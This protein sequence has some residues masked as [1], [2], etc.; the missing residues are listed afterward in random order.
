[1]GCDADDDGG[2][3]KLA[4]IP[5]LVFD[6]KRGQEVEGRLDR[7][8]VTLVLDYMN[9]KHGIEKCTEGEYHRQKH[10]MSKI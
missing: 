1:M 4:A 3:I 2:S 6:N 5:R 7:D 9:D 8:M 10:Q